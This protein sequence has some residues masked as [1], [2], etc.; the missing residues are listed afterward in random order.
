MQLKLEVF[1]INSVDSTEVVV[2]FKA[3]RPFILN[4]SVSVS[5]HSVFSLCLRFCDKILY[6]FLFSQ[7]RILRPCSIFLRVQI[8]QVLFLRFLNTF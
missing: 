8:V 1:S 3:V 7:L 4:Y 5:R 6:I 2:N